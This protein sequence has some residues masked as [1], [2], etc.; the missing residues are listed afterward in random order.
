MVGSNTTSATRDIGRRSAV[1]SRLCNGTIAVAR[2]AAE[3][4]EVTSLPKERASRVT[5]SGPDSRVSAVS[6]PGQRRG[7]SWMSATGSGVS[8]RSDP[9]RTDGVGSSKVERCGSNARSSLSCSVAAAGRASCAGEPVVPS[10]GSDA[11]D[12]CA[13]AV[14]FAADGAGLGG[15]SR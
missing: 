12:A 4:S 6:L 9:T 3:N 14:T 7:T 1:A 11:T 5:I 13:A 2:C 15:S 10:A 8:S